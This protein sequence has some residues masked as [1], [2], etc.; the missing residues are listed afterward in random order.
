MVII[1]DP[2]RREVRISCREIVVEGEAVIRDRIQIFARTCTACRWRG[3]GECRFLGRVGEETFE[4]VVGTA[5]L[6]ETGGVR[7]RFS[8]RYLDGGRIR[9][10]YVVKNPRNRIRDPDGF[11]AGLRDRLGRLGA[12][13]TKI[14]S[15]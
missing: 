8:I 1:I 14:S 3:C 6:E 13:I 10:R 2:L 12:E 5:I 9:F 4:Y 7:W 11:M 15:R